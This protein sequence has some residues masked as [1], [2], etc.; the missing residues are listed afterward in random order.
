MRVQPRHSLHI[1][2]IAHHGL[3]ILSSFL[4]LL[5][6]LW[7]I[8]ISFSATGDVLDRFLILFPSSFGI[9]G[10]K[11]VFDLVPYERWFLN[12]VF[13]S[14]V[15]TT[16]QLI[17]G[18]FAAFA[19]SRFKFKGREL[20]FFFVLCTMMIPPQAIMLPAFM[21][22][23]SFGLVNTYPGL[24]LPHM[25]H[26]YV[27]FMLRQFFLQVPKDLDESSQIDGANSMQ[28]LYHVYLTSAL[29]A[30][31]SVTLIQL[32]RNW[33]DYYWALVVLSEEVK[34][35]LPVGIVSFRDETL[36]RW[37]PTM[38]SALMSVI[39]VI[40]LYLFGQRYF[41]E[42]NLGSGMK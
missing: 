28:T 36:V 34:L 8:S 32:V 23:N 19:L 24:M 5:P 35:T 27:I 1:L 30:V 10:F 16:A 37:V 7:M 3:L 11:E 25:A 39:P 4:V 41:L 18:V 6:F 20:L 40:I 26:G 31:I 21:V 2:H 17:L 29:P 42:T 38:A 15:L 13:V 12:S 9:E 22:I 14:T 33:N